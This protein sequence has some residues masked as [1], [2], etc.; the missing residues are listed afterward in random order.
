[1][2]R[3]DGEV[4]AEGKPGE[5]A[6]VYFRLPLAAERDVESKTAEAPLR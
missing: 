6:S 4:W 3:H 5:G 2:R 1:M